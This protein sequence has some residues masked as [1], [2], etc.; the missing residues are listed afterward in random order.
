M[1]GDRWLALQ[2]RGDGMISRP[3][4]LMS[5][6]PYS[7]TTGAGCGYS[8]GGSRFSYTGQNEEDIL[9]NS[10]GIVYNIDE[11]VSLGPMDAHLL[12]GGVTP[13]VGDYSPEKPLK[14]VKVL[15]SLY[16][17]LLPRDIVERVQNCNRPGGQ[18][19][20][21]EDEAKDLLIAWKEAM[22][23]NW[24]KGWEDEDDGPV[25]F[26]SFFDDGGGAIGSTGRMLTEITLDN[27]TLTA[28]SIV[29][30][31]LFSAAFLFSTDLVESRVLV[32]LVGVGLVVLSFFSSLGFGLLTGIQINVVCMLS[33]LFDMLF[34][35]SLTLPSFVDHCL[36][37]A[38]RNHWYVKG[39][40]LSKVTWCFN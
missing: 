24:N 29:I 27:S 9:G 12:L 21:T 5:P 22:E 37:V 35:S 36:D 31:S 17:A 8:L 34:G 11:G 26:V 2:S 13:P 10:S 28:I 14:E 1:V 40:A 18:V 19:V 6:D 16:A 3:S 15:Q 25:E 30:I 20:L 33:I 7:W 23:E 38:F 32:T 39:C 4:F